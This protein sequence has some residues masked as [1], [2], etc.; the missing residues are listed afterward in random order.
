MLIKPVKPILNLYINVPTEVGGTPTILFDA[1]SDA[2]YQ[3]SLK[4]QG[5]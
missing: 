1:I 4:I 3:P 5:T 2:N